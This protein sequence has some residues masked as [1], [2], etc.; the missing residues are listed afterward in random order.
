MESHPQFKDKAN[1]TYK[2]YIN[3]QAALLMLFVWDP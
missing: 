1:P 2:G 3:L